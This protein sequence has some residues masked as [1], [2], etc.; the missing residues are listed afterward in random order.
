MFRPDLPIK[1]IEEEKKHGLGRYK[2]AQSLGESILSY[3]ETESL[4]IG[5]SGEWGSGKTSIVNMTLD[6]IYLSER[7]DEK[8]LIMRFNP[9][10][11]S[12]HNQLIE[13]FFN[14]L[15]ILL[16]DESKITEKLKSYFNKLIPPVLLLSSL[17][18]PGPTQALISSARWIEEHPAKSFESIKTELNELLIKNNRKI[19][20]VIEDIDRLNNYEIRQMFQ[21]VKLL[22]NFSNTVYIMEFDKNIVIK[23]LEKD[24]P[25]IYSPQ[26]LEKIVQVIFDVPKMTDLELEFI[27]NHEIEEL[28]K[29]SPNLFNK[30]RWIFYCQNGLTYLFK[31]IR[32][33][34]RYINNL[35]FNF[36][37]LK[38]EVDLA[39]L[40]A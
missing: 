22:A 17:T 15:S 35:K 1:T 21:L 13:K 6:Y 27:L 38:N 31:D 34:K 9:W 36:G 5:I 28:I 18:S 4:V 7:D 24:M 30:E 32:A 20:I 8:P 29:D 25:K 10:N 26:Y 37:L 23:A 11:F 40:F 33:I 12:D 3:K 19:I 16:S 39:D 2:F 14:E